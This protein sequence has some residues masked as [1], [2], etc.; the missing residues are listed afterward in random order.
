MLNFWV[1]VVQKSHSWKEPTRLRPG[2]CS[3]PGRV[4]KNFR[5]SRYERDALTNERHCRSER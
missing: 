4:T 3:T 2:R 5:A 1:G